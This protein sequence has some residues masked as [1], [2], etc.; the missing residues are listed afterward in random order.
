MGFLVFMLS[1]D[2]VHFIIEGFLK[3]FESWFYSRRDIHSLVGL[4]LSQEFLQTPY[5]FC[6][7][8]IAT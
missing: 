5:T 4:L 3:I 7:P 1:V 2:M 6:A 8:L